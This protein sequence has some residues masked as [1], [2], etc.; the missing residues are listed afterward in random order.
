[1][2]HFKPFYTTLL[3]IA[4]TALTSMTAT[5]SAQEQLSGQWLFRNATPQTEISQEKIQ[6]CLDFYQK[7]G[8]VIHSLMILRHGQ[9]VHEQWFLDNAPEKPHVLHSVSKT[10]T[11][12][13]VGF[14]V[15]EGLLK[16]SDKVIS[17]FPDLLPEDVSDNLKDMEI[18]D[19][20]TMTTGNDKAF[21][22]NSLTA[23]DNWAKCFLANPVEH[24]PGTFYAYNTLGT[25]MLSAIVQKVTGQRV[26]D[27]LQPRLFDPLG[28]EPP[29]WQLS[30]QG[31]NTGG[32]GLYLK[33]ED[34][35][36]MGQFYLQKGK[37]NGKQLLNASWIEEASSKQVPCVPAGSRPDTPGLD[38]VNNDWTQGY[39]YQIWRCRHN[40]YRADG[41]N[42]QYII[43]LPDYDAVIVATSNT[44]KLQT[45]LNGFWDYLLPAFR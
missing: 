28:I 26:V 13:A 24:T 25:Y 1:M 19:L 36:K 44:G 23:D 32:F 41:A 20:L 42:G 34:L 33:T 3:T 4:L 39:G 37:W 21:N 18:F 8:V 9:V 29:Y 22:T 30:P 35:A 7:E 6:E 45:V 14:A 43:V 5:V 2:S 16:V 38:Y 31:I 11:S 27:Y 10:F 12:T 17:F 40:A 15:Q